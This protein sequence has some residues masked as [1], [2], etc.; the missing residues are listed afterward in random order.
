MERIMNQSIRPEAAWTFLLRRS[1]V[2]MGIAA[3][4]AL[5]ALSLS[6]TILPFLAIDPH[7]FAFGPK[8]FFSFHVLRLFLPWIAFLTVFITLA[9][10]EFRITKNGYRHRVIVIAAGILLPV[11]A[12]AIIF[13]LFRVNEFSD[14]EFRKR[15]PPY[16]GMSETPREFW[17]HPKDGFLAGTILSAEPNSVSFQS[18]SGDT[19]T[20]II[21][22]RTIIHPRVRLEE[23]KEIR[24]I[25]EPGG[26]ELIRAERIFP[27]DGQ[28]LG[29]NNG[30]ETSI[31]GPKSRAAQ[32]APER[33]R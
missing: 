8:R 12:A 26:K 29:R 1:L 32:T 30:K 14:R 2:W 16:E 23:G 7:L 28:R 17:S 31:D 3:A 10:A 15:I 5:A 6:M 24:I 13:H 20:V 25:G 11:V 27:S 9:I 19:V 4:G 21:D 22:D 18:M 33:G